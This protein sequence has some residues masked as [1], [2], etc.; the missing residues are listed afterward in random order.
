MKEAPKEICSEM[1]PINPAYVSGR[2]DDP[3]E[4]PKKGTF[5]ESFPESFSGRA[6]ADLW[7]KSLRIYQRV[8]SKTENQF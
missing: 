4:L 7:K 6:T 1:R 2:A 3:T 8:F 5:A